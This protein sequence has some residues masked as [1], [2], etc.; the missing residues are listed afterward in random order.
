MGKTGTATGPATNSH[1]MSRPEVSATKGKPPT[2]IKGGTLATTF[3]LPKPS[4]K[5]NTNGNKR[6]T[7][8]QKATPATEGDKVKPPCC[9]HSYA[10]NGTGAQTVL[11]SRERQTPQGIR[12]LQRLSESD[13]PRIILLPGLRREE[14]ATTPPGKDAPS[15]D[16]CRANRRLPP[17]NLHKIRC[18]YPRNT[19]NRLPVTETGRECRL[20]R[21]KLH[22]RNQQRYNPVCQPTEH[23]RFAMT[24]PD[25]TA[26][27]H[28]AQQPFRLPDPPQREPDAGA[29]GPNPPVVLGVEPGE[30][31]VHRWATSATLLPVP[32]GRRRCAQ[33]L[34]PVSPRAV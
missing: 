21:L 3:T 18:Q 20:E 23:Q 17:G 11:K 16:L 4:N 19:E 31:A 33:Q 10:G 1:S 30:T 12:P 26:K 24:T 9:R 22:R 28:K 13:H 6:K 15:S 25:A 32:A 27:L 29:L 7:R 5:G 34:R 2:R 8:S 14:P